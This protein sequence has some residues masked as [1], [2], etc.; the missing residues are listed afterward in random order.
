M[1]FTTLFTLAVIVCLIGVGIRVSTW[2]SQG[3]HPSTQP[4]STPARLTAALQGVVASVFSSRLLL[5]IKSFFV[6]LLFQKRIFDKNKLRWVAH[7]LIFFGFMLLLLM[8]AMGSLISANI[9]S[10]YQPTLNPFLFLRN[11]FGLMVLA[12]VCIAIYRRITLKNQR[13]VTYAS[14]WTALIFLI[15]IIGSGVLLEGAKIS[16]YSTYQ[17][18]V[19]EYGAASDDNEAKA[20]EA[21][22]VQENGLVS[23]NFSG[24]IDAELVTLGKEVNSMSCIECHAANSNAFLSYSLAGVTRPFAAVL[25]DSGAVSMFWYLHILACLGF[26]AWL[27]FSKMFHVL[28]APISLMIK[29][30]TNDVIKE[31]ANALSRQMVGLSACTHCGTCSLECSSNMFFESFD[32]EFILPS[33]KVQYLKNIASGKEKDPKVLKKMQQ[34]LYVCTSCDRCT[35][36]CPSGINLKEIFVSARYAL[37]EQGVPERTLLSHFS[38]PLALAQNF[39]DSHLSALKKVTEQF[40]KSFQHLAD[41]TGPIHLGGAASDAVNISY[42]GCYSCQRCTNVCPVVRSYDNPVENLGMLPHQI[43]Y[44]LGLG[45]R[46]LAMGAQMIWSCSTC[47][48][49]QEHCPNQVELT[50]IFYSLKNSALSKIEAGANA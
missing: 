26:L 43:I 23:P 3:I 25:G 32:N 45:N 8:H 10:D 5:I 40:K 47:Y 50:D 14:D 18:M 36:V 11:F 6:D 9:F 46:E 31:P 41:I 22:W 42:R 4:H 19:D 12:G 49:C 13:L 28:S 21:F 37:L 35:T 16:S 20:L 34:G 7:T 17:R 15:V 2:F 24:P 38:F 39:V 1:N 33:E 48:L 27:P 29:G 30:S 44:T